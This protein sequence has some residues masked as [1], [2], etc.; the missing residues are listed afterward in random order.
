MSDLN[1]FDANTI[2]PVDLEPIEDGHYLAKIIKSELKQ[3]KKSTGKY[4]ELTFQILDG[5]YKDKVLWARLNLHNPNDVAVKIAKQELSAICRA[6]NVMTPR[7]SIELHNLPLVIR[8]KCKKRQD[9]G[10][11][12]NEIKGYFKKD[13]K[14]SQVAT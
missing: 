14:A 12:Q 7:D 1:G 9:T 5:R 2:E 6:V 8:V 10:D 4:L 3:N 13:Y 11:I